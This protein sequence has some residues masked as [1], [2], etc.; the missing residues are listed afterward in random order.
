ML[1]AINPLRGLSQ[2][3][4]IVSVR[5]GMAMFF[6]DSEDAP[7]EDVVIWVKAGSVPWEYPK[8]WEP[9]CP[10]NMTR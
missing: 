4:H 9:R 10:F 8:T 7:F 1:N 5:I 2:E 6:N 3:L